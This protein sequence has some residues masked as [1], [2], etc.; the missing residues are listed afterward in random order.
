MTAGCASD[1]E[2]HAMMLEPVFRRSPFL[3]GQTPALITA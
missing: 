2:R 3:S 1:P